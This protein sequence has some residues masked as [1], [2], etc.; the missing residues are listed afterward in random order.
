MLEKEKAKHKRA[1]KLGLPREVQKQTV[2]EYLSFWLEKIVKIECA[3]KTYISY[4]QMARLHISPLIGGVRLSELRPQHVR[5]MLAEK[6]LSGLSARSVQYLRAILRSALSAAVDDDVLEMNVATRAKGPTGTAKEVEPLTPDQARAVLAAVRGHRLEAL[7]TVAIAL[8]MRQGETIG[9]TWEHVDLDA[10]TLR[11]EWQLQRLTVKLPNGG[12]RT[13]IPLGPPKQHSR[14]T[15]TLPQTV[16]KA[17]RDH[18]ERQQDER[19]LCGSSWRTPVVIREGK[20]VAAEF[21]FTT[22][23]GTPLEPC[24]LN[25]TFGAILTACGIAHIATTTCGTPPPRFS[26]CKRSRRKRS[27]EFLDGPKFRCSNATRTWSMRCEKKPPKRWTKCSPP[28]APKTDEPESQNPA[29]KNLV[30][31]TWH[32]KPRL[33]RVK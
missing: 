19:E 9:L 20:Q 17:L 32:P 22:P 12:K 11:V 4:E 6:T 16:L 18:H 13:D 28:R 14:R 24:N 3:P 33:Y 23:I 27:C 31:S 26:R 15:I 7:F 25:K 10:G 1:E 30:A 29:G 21:V 5:A 8:G 2:A